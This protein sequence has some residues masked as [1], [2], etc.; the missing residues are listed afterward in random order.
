[1]MN[2]STSGLLVRLLTDQSERFRRGQRILV[3]AYLQNF[4]ALLGD[5]EQ[6]LDLISNEIYLRITYDDNPSL[7][8]YRQ[9]F[10]DH[11]AAIELQFQLHQ[12]AGS[13][14]QSTTPLSSS[15]ILR[16]TPFSQWIHSPKFPVMKSSANWYRCHGSGL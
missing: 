13:Q 7:Q 5:Q 9:R 12:T 1:M 16:S 3:E 6:L 10:P 14:P 15:A 11:T 4:P 8:E 2:N